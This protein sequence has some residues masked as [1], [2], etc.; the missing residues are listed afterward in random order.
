MFSVEPS[1]VAPGGE[2]WDLIRVDIPHFCKVKS[3]TRPTCAHSAEQEGN[4]NPVWAEAQHGYRNP[5]GRR[6]KVTVQA[7]RKVYG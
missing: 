6:M 1:L 2:F 4:F 7:V 3:P 5:F